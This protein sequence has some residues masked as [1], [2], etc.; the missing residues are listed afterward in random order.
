MTEVENADGEKDHGHGGFVIPG[1]QV[2]VGDTVYI[3]ATAIDINGQM[4]AQIPHVDGTPD[5]M[6][7]LHGDWFEK[8]QALEQRFED[9]L[10]AGMRYPDAAL[11]YRLAAVRAVLDSPRVHGGRYA[12]PD[13]G[14]EVV[15]MVPVKDVEAALD[16]E[17]IGLEPP[18]PL[19]WKFDGGRGAMVTESGR[20]V[21]YYNPRQPD[22]NLI[23]E[24]VYDALDAG[25][26]ADAGGNLI[27]RNSLAHLTNEVVS[28]VLS[29]LLEPQ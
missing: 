3:P 25:T 14:D 1:G 18:G 19:R 17:P 13:L 6:I 8:D 2:E 22:P 16:G 5:R 21:G 26:G 23:Q 11:R 10:D 9:G 15:Y 4:M 29:K 12:S 20:I 27:L 7:A 28:A 24:A